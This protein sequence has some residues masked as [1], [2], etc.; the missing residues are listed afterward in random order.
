MKI[1]GCDL[2]ARQQTS[3]GRAGGE[4]YREEI[5]KHKHLWS[6]FTSTPVLQ[7]NR[8][9]QSRP[10]PPSFDAADGHSDLG[11]QSGMSSPPSPRHGLGF[12][13]Q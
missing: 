1:V 13:D 10:G 4:G 12:D 3:C 5:A 2:H 8:E 11:V 9:Q 7:Q 6:D